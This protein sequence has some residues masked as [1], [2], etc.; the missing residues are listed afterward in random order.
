MYD[1]LK[2]FYA[3]DSEV[4]NAAQK[5]MS[6]EETLK[7]MQDAESGNITNA[8]ADQYFGIGAKDMDYSQLIDAYLKDGGDPSKIGGQFASY[9]PKE[10][11]GARSANTDAEMQRSLEAQLATE[12]RREAPID[13]YAGGDESYNQLYGDIPMAA[14]GLASLPEYKAGG[15]LDGPGDGMSDSIP[16]VIKGEQPQRAALADGE[17][18]VPADVVSHLG[19]GSTKAGSARLYEMM[20][21][22]R[23]A[24]TGNS[25]QGKKINPHKFLPV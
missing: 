3:R 20:D 11:S 8:N 5:P 12:G 15:L 17:F 24:R 2:K 19:N 1:T 6:V 10:A 4:L 25:K 7:L 9:M 14:G 22:I 21:K 18:V 13:A 23:H 16:A